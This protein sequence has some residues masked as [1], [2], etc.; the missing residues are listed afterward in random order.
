[1]TTVGSG[2]IISFPCMNPD[3]HMRLNQ[4][5][6]W[7]RMIYDAMTQISMKSGMEISITRGVYELSKKLKN[8][9][10]WNTFEP[11]D[12]HTIIK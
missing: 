11:L 6:Y 8:L 9:Y 10:L 4:G 7:E 2:V 1:M 3:N 5:T 12:P